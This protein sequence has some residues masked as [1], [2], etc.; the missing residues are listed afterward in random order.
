MD[1]AL[2]E[3]GHRLTSMMRAGALPSDMEPMEHWQVFL[4]RGIHDRVR[5][6][7]DGFLNPRGVS[8]GWLTLSD[9]ANGPTPSSSASSPRSGQAGISGECEEWRQAS[10]EGHCRAC[11]LR[12]PEAE[13]L[14]PPAPGLQP[15]V[16]G[17]RFEEVE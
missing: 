16:A 15:Q 2:R 6:M 5:A 9:L 11:L 3:V 14:A 1:P 10:L 4:L 7:V 17:N 12:L 8:P 13:R